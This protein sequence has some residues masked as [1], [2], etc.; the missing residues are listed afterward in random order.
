[1]IFLDKFDIFDS[2]SPINYLHKSPLK[3]LEHCNPMK[4][5][6]VLEDVSENMNTQTFTV[7]DV[8]HSLQNIGHIIMKGKYV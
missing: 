1:M 7:S 3:T 8:M 6:D 5:S 4:H 2:I